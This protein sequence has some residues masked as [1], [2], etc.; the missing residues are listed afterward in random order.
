[1]SDSEGDLTGGFTNEQIEAELAF[2]LAALGRSVKAG[3]FD[4]PEGY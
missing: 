4:W 1:M 2:F 3:V